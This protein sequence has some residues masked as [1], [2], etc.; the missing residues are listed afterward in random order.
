VDWINV[1]G[2]YAELAGCYEHNKEL[3]G[4]MKGKEFFDYLSICQLLKKHSAA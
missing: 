4:F 2:R 1:A 3:L